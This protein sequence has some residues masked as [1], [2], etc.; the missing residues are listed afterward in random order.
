[1]Y[2]LLEKIPYS[3]KANDLKLKTFF[4]IPKFSLTCIG[5]AV[6][7]HFHTFC[8]RVWASCIQGHTWHNSGG[9][10]VPSP[11]HV[12]ERLRPTT[13]QGVRTQKQ[14]IQPSNLQLYPHELQVLINWWLMQ[15]LSRHQFADTDDLNPHAYIHQLLYLISY[16]SCTDDRLWQVDKSNRHKGIRFKFMT[17]PFPLCCTQLSDGKLE[18]LTEIV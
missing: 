5:H 18:H 8:N 12:S 16:H 9:G 1:M 14:L 7:L 10:V 15:F 2:P 3:T 11:I 6:S 17:Y 4:F 13:H